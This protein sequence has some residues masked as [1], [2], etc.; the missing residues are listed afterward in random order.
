MAVLSG[1]RVVGPSMV[2]LVQVLRL[3]TTLRAASLSL[4]W[5][6]VGRMVALTTMSMS[7]FPAMSDSTATLAALVVAQS[8]I[9]LKTM[10]TVL[11]QLLS[12]P[13]QMAGT[14]AEPRL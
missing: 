1:R 14:K 11:R 7:P 3:L 8:L 2:A 13:T 12:T 5:T 6:W 4:T 10:V 9:L